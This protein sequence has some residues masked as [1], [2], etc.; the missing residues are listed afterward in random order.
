MPIKTVDPKTLKKWLKTGEAV[1]VDVREPDEYKAES[2]P[3]SFHVPLGKV[4]VSTLPKTAGK[5]MVVHCKA[6]KRG[7][8]ACEKL[9]AEN[10]DLELYNLEG[11]IDKWAQAGYDVICA[12]KPSSSENQLAE[13]IIGVGVVLGVMLGYMA[14]PAFFLIALFFGAGLI[15]SGLT[16]WCGVR[17]LIEKCPKE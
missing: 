11:G 2:I 13:L 15:I 16:G 17:L 14:H 9:L 10:P 1:L 4:C 6:G 12:D 7:G 8:V 5:K 3:E